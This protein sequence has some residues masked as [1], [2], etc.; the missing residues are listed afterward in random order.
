MPVWVARSWTVKPLSSSALST[1]AVPAVPPPASSKTFVALA[2]AAC[3][4]AITLSAAL[5]AV[6]PFIIVVAKFSSAV[7]PPKVV[8]PSTSRSLSFSVVGCWFCVCWATLLV[9]LLASD[10]TSCIVLPAKAAAWSTRSLTPRTVASSVR[11]PSSIA[12]ANV[13]CPLRTALMVS[14]IVP[15]IVPTLV[16]LPGIWPKTLTWPVGIQGGIG[17]HCPWTPDGLPAI[18]PGVVWNHS[19]APSIASPT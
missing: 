7:N 2:K 19:P 13:I 3:W 18:T 6:F 17:P 8:P 15:V 5:A 14:R 16:A 4:S 12:S 9:T 11:P 1:A 10:I